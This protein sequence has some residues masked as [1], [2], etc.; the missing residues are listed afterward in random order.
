MTMPIIS[1]HCPVAD[2]SKFQYPWAVLKFQDTKEMIFEAMMHAVF[3]LMVWSTTKVV[4]I[5][6]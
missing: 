6:T 2:S 4:I 5:F 3:I 1:S